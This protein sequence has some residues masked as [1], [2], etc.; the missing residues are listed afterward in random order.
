MSFW[1]ELILVDDRLGPFVEVLLGVVLGNVVLDLMGIV[2]EPIV[3]HV[4]ILEEVLASTV[5]GK[6][7]VEI[8][9]RVL[10]LIAD[11]IDVHVDKDLNHDCLV[12][13][14]DIAVVIIV[15]IIMVVVIAFVAFVVIVVVIVVVVA[16]FV[17]V[18]VVI[19]V[20]AV[21]IVVVA[22][23]IVVVVLLVVVK[24]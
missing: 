3:G 16:V 15:V 23:V 20:V 2:D 22:V 21:V 14:V 1:I 19:V 11:A 12:I 10:D 6:A 9:R 5:L 24:R 8:F 17:V 13:V 7:L 18:V 4:D